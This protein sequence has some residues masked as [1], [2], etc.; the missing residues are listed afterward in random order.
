MS[1]GESGNVAARLSRRFGAVVRDQLAID[2][3]Q[4]VPAQRH[5]VIV[6]VLAWLSIIGLYVAGWGKGTVQ[7][8]G[9]LA[10]EVYIPLDYGPETLGRQLAGLAADAGV[11]L[12]A[13]VVLIAFRRYPAP[14]APFPVVRPQTRLRAFFVA[15]LAVTLGFG[16]TGVVNAL[17]GGGNDYPH[18]SIDGWPAMAL[19]AISGA[20]AGPMEELALLAVVVT[21]LRRSGYGWAVVCI[22][23]VAVRVPFHVFY[24]WGSLMLAVWAVLMV[25]LYRRVGTAVPIAAAHALWNF[26]ATPGI[27][28]VTYLVKHACVIVG[29]VI[30]I[31]TLRRELN[32]ASS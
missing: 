28:E 18:P 25:A 4:L 20:M 12:A 27:F 7:A 26:I 11:V 30:L 13:I 5:L 1:R 15:P 32:T 8:V 6:R 19:Y 22:A 29:L 16:L 21:V 17:L 23:A 31:L 3:T 14:A 9:I 2:R 10:G 24:G